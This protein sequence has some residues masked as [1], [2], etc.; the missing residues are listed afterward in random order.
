MKAENS[1][2]TLKKAQHETSFGSL[3]S[4]IERS[5]DIIQTSRRVTEHTREAT[6]PLLAG[7]T[8]SKD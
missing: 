1:D 3:E 8:P 7:G 2:Q 5:R 6:S 4:L